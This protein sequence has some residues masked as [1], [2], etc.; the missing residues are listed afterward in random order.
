MSQHG[1]ADFEREGDDDDGE[2]DRRQ[3]GVTL[4]DLPVPDYHAGHADGHHDVWR[5]RVAHVAVEREQ[6]EWR[7]DDKLEGHHAQPD[8][9]RILH[10]QP[11]QIV[12]ISAHIHRRQEGVP[13]EVK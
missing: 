7:V 1:E 12:E 11:V 4:P 8:R 6:I 2:Y 10:R 5:E 13:P 9:A 3:Y